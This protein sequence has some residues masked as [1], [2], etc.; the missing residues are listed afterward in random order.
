MTSIQILM[1]LQEKN[2]LP[3]I[4]LITNLINGKTYVGKHNGKNEYYFGSGQNIVRAIKKYGKENFTKTILKQGDFNNELLSE[5]EKHYIRLYSPAYT[6]NSYNLTLGGEGQFG[7]IISEETKILMSIKAKE[8]FKDPIERLKAGNGS[9]GK[10][11]PETTKVALLKAV[12]GNKWNLGKPLKEETKQKLSTIFKG[13]TYTDEQRK[14]MSDGRKGMKFSEE[15]KKAL[16]L[17][18]Q[19]SKNNK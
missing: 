15:H 8:R 19:K 16:S 9:R 3:Y 6:P 7:R 11:M 10:S 1:N 17:A 18:K 4:Y 12:T 13:R 14:R 2:K 5:L